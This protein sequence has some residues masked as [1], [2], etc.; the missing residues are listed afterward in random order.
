[1]AMAVAFWRPSVTSLILDVSRTMKK[2]DCFGAISR[3]SLANMGWCSLVL[4]YVH[5]CCQD[6]I[7][8]LPV[9][10]E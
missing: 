7:E 1:M 5:I 2:L 10:G 9:R 8:F 6:L 3:R 4:L